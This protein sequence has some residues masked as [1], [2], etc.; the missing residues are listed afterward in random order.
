[1]TGSQLKPPPRK[2]LQA[3]H[4][5]QIGADTVGTYLQKGWSL[6]IC[7][8]GCERLVEWTPPDLARRYGDR[9]ALRIADVAERLTCSGEQGCGS[10]EIAVFP[11]PYDG[12][13]SW[14]RST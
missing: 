9:P 3:F 12:P 7:C 5:G 10:R 4:V 8:K 6:A 2:A 13:W 11:H 1:M 14:P